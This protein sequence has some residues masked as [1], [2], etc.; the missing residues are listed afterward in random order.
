MNTKDFVEQLYRIY[1]GR[2]S[3][4][5]ES[6]FWV[7]KIDKQVATAFEVTEV[8]INDAYFTE[9]VV[10]IARLYFT[11]FERLPDVTGLLFWIEKF[12]Q[13]ISLDD[14]ASALLT[15]SEFDTSYSHLSGNEAYLKQLY[16]NTFDHLPNSNELTFLLNALDKGLQWNDLVIR[17][18]KLP[19]FEKNHGEKINITLKYFSILGREPTD[20]E[21]SEAIEESDPVALIGRLYLNDDYKGEPIP[22]LISKGTVIGSGAIADA[23]VFIDKNDNDLLDEGELSTKTDNSGRWSFVGDETFEGK[24]VAFGGI[25]ISTS[26]LV[27]GTVTVEGGTSIIQTTTKPLSSSL[28][29]TTGSVPPVDENTIT[30]REPQILRIFVTFDEPIQIETIPV[31]SINNGTSDVI[32]FASMAN[33]SNITYYYDLAVPSGD[34]TGT[35]IINTKAVQTET[36]TDVIATNTLFVVDNA[37]ALT[38]EDVAFAIDENSGAGQAV[39][40]IVSNDVNALYSLK[41]TGDRDFFSVDGSTGIVRLIS[42]PDFETKPDY[43]FTAVSSDTAGNKNE[44][45]VTLKINDVDEIVPTVSAVS[46]TTADGSY[47]VGDVIAVTVAFSEIIF[48][49][50]TPT[51]TLKIGE[52]EKTINYLSGAGSNTLTFDYIVAAEDATSDL[53]YASTAALGLNGGSIKDESG[54]DAILTLAVLA[55]AKSLAGSKAI[56]LDNVAPLLTTEGRLPIDGATGITVDSNITLTFNEDI[57][58]GT[59]NITLTSGSDNIV[60]TE[61]ELSVSGKVL[62]INPNNDLGKGLS[63]YDVVIGAGSIT[64]L[65]GNPYAGLS[66]NNYS[67]ETAINTNIVVFDMTTGNSSSHSNRTF[68]TNVDYK[69]YIKVNSNSDVFTTITPWTGGANLGAGDEI[70]LVGSGGAPVQGVNMNTVLS[71]GKLTV[72][73]NKIEWITIVNEAA[74]DGVAMVL[75]KS[76]IATRLFSIGTNKSGLWNGSAHIELV[77]NDYKINMPAGILS[78]QGLI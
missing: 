48:V 34:F 52:I 9:T 71:K 30:V 61:S 44:R 11:I 63:T 59:S 24:I 78:S 72:L 49:T 32:S 40:S 17:A 54:N 43:R 67:F 4:E 20:Q 26:Q 42:N 5:G 38:S 12:N 58:V 25:D 1:L 33:I 37:P 60:I 21:L 2:G 8:F 39:Y 75:N 69:L 64:D 23:T 76:G 73:K 53:D 57:A 56:V 22:H 29:Y 31:I 28:R 16:S 68:K 27:E 77:G 41:N 62:T 46:S 10:P 51:L 50:G 35:V 6:L 55:S 66:A 47:K 70:I 13:G 14:I 36:I 45:A 65:A 15:S 7:D 19:E 18:S 74:V 3:L